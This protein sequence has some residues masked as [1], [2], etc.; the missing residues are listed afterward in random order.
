MV[1][2]FPKDISNP[3]GG[4]E[5]ATISLA[6]ALIENGAIDIH[7]ITVEHKLDTAIQEDHAGINVHRLPRSRFPMFIDVFGGPTI[8]RLNDY[9]QNLSPDIVHY[10]ETWGF[11]AKTAPC[12]SIFTVHGFDSLNIPTQ[13]PRFWKT[14]SMI[15]RWAE[16]KGLKHQKHLISIAPYV[17]REIEKNSNAQIFDIWNSLV[18]DYFQLKRKPKNNS[19]LFLGWLNPR[20][21]PLS[22]IKSSIHLIE[23]FPKIQV[24]LCGEASDAEYYQELKDTIARLS[25]EKHVFM[26]GRQSQ[27]QVMEKLSTATMLVLPS[28]QE[29]APMV[30]A[31][32]MAAGVPVVAS[33]KCG[34]PDMI[35]HGKSGLLIDPDDEFELPNAIGAL[36]RD[37]NLRNTIGEQAKIVAQNRFHPSSVAK[38][39]T[40]VY[41]QVITELTEN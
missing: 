7:I 20:K 30:V 37:S 25:L 23:E 15:W 11:S 2:R 6:K 3:R 35:E 1:S 28:Y 34:I 13:K 12:P 17:K 39:T 16:K 5:T 27:E 32:A 29:N 38:K 9:I 10:H 18:E 24:E 31:E 4:V 26:P 21:N 40:E 36:L 22:V 14:R 19:I 41:T 8:R 33:N